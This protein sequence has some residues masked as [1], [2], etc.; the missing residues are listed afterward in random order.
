M[1]L[2]KNFRPEKINDITHVR[3]HF[4][5]LKEHIENNESTLPKDL[6][7]YTFEDDNIYLKKDDGDYYPIAHPDLSTQPSV[8]P[9]RFGNI[10]IS[11][12]LVPSTKVY[13]KKEYIVPNTS[14]IYQVDIDN[15]PTGVSHDKAYLKPDGF[16]YDINERRLQEV[17]VTF[18]TDAA[19]LAV[20]VGSDNFVY[21]QIANP[22]DMAIHESGLYVIFGENNLI[23]LCSGERPVDN[24]IEL[25]DTVTEYIASSRNIN[26]FV[27]GGIYKLP[28]VIDEYIYKDDLNYS[29]RENQLTPIKNKSIIKTDISIVPSNAVVIEASAFN[30]KESSPATTTKNNDGSITITPLKDINP[31]FG[32]IRYYSDNKNNYYYAD[33]EDDGLKFIGIARAIS[34]DSIPT[35]FYTKKDIKTEDFGALFAYPYIALK[36]NQYVVIP[37]IIIN[38]E[39]FDSNSTAHSGGI[40]NIIYVKDSY[41]I[42]GT[43]PFINT[44]IRPGVKMTD[45]RLKIGGKTYKLQ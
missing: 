33:K 6:D 23:R 28:I 12:V 7:N 31:D 16:F 42:I 5:M 43:N 38:I 20:Y 34:E 8:L 10:P 37:D 36:F 44:E 30:G 45:I 41:I 18:H 24:K 14:N 4:E 9:Q 2:T 22:Y 19:I 39:I 17:K 35:D 26:E 1:E 25:Y 3:Q 11:E 40:M 15:T 27:D 13:G 29:P 32:L 21:Y